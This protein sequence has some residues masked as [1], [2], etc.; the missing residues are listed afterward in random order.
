MARQSPPRGVEGDQF[1]QPV[2][3][4]KVPRRDRPDEEAALRSQIDNITVL[5]PRLDPV[6]VR[7]DVAAERDVLAA[8]AETERKRRKL[9]VDRLPGVRAPARLV[10]PEARAAVSSRRGPETDV[11]SV[12]GAQVEQL[13]TL[14]PLR[15]L[16]H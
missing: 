2:S 14:R 6:D 7:A 11:R 13:L 10:R 4:R 1:Y 8:C 9:A 16:R 12:V 5:E 15:L 3:A